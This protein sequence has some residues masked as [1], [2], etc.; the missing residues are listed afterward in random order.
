MLADAR[1]VFQFEEGQMAFRHI[2]PSASYQQLFRLAN[3]INSIQS[4]LASHILV[5][6]SRE[7]GGAGA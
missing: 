1:L 2:N 7:F 4:D 3:A 5:V 6:T